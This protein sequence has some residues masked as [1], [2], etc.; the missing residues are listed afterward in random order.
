MEATEAGE[1]IATPDHSGILVEPSTITIAPSATIS[2]VVVSVHGGAGTS[3]LAHLLGG[4]VAPADWEAL[5]DMST[6]VILVARAT[7]DAAAKATDAVRAAVVANACIA[8]LVVVADGPWP[9]PVASRARYRMLEQ[10]VGAVIR[11]PY[12]GRWRYEAPT[13]ATATRSARRALDQIR[14]AIAA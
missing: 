10:E 4:A 5:A 1:R 13:P 11:L 9:E 12:V 3:T 8:A 7:P 6:P 2:S 14:A